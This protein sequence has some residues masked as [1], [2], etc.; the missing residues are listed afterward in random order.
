MHV[1]QGGLDIPGGKGG[2]REEG[3]GDEVGG[4]DEEGA[5][6]P[7][8]G[9]FGWSRLGK[10]GKL[11]RSAVDL[12]QYDFVCAQLVYL[13]LKHGILLTDLE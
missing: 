2:S 1:G 8:D 10:E 4:G 11:P 3:G 12:D 13:D 7:V 5:E 9:V 6:S